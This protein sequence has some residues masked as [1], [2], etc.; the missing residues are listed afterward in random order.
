MTFSKE[1]LDK[2][3]D[4][5][6]YIDCTEVEKIIDI[7]IEVRPKGRLFVIGS[8]GG[9]GHASHAVCD[10]RKLCGIDALSLD[11]L[12]FLTAVTNDD[13]WPLTTLSWLK[14]SRFNSNDCLFVISVGGGTLG[15][16]QNLVNAVRFAKSEG[17]KVVGIVGRDGG[18]TRQ[19]ADATILIQTKGYVTPITESVQ[20]IIWHLLVSDQ[21]LAIN[22]TKW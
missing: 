16:S 2:V 15:V 20:A 14:T 7:L 22:K 13:G 5:I 1:F 11:N 18:I 4:S 17:A 3:I 9:A 8:G 21:R 10:F 12:S 19:M 6:R